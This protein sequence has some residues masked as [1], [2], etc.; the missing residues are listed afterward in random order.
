M[1][2]SGNC[3]ATK[4]GYFKAFSGTGMSAEEE[5]HHL[6]QTV[7]FLKLNRRKNSLAK[8]QKALG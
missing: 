1:M 5:T 4:E 8:P 6:M 3:A 2:C 7:S